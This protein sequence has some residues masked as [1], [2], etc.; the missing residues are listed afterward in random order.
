MNNKKMSDQILILEAAASVRKELLQNRID[1]EPDIM[2][3]PIL[4]R[5][6]SLYSLLDLDALK[7]VVEEAEANEAEFETKKAA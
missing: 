1:G 6:C 2:T 5:L 4:V 7:Q 3:T